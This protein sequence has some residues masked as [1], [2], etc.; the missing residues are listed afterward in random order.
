[1]KPPRTL[2][3]AVTPPPRVYLYV[4]F[5]SA[6]QSKGDSVRRQEEMGD[7]F[8]RERHIKINEILRIT[9]EGVSGFRGRNRTHGALSGFLDLM[10][11]KKIPQGSE[12]WVEN[13]DRLSRDYLTEA[14]PVFMAIV[15]AGITIVT[16]DDG[17]EFSKKIIN[18]DPGRMIVALVHMST[19]HD[20]SEIKSGRGKEAW[21]GKRKKIKTLKLTKQ[22]PA[23][24]KLSDDRTDFELIDDRV[25][26]VRR[27][28]RDRARGIGVFRL[29]REL[30]KRKVPTWGRGKRRAYQW[31][32]S[33]VSKILQ[34]RSVLGEFQA[35]LLED[36]KRVPEGEVVLEY[37]PRIISNELFEQVQ[38]LR[39]EDTKRTG[40]IGGGVPNLFTW[41]TKCARTGTPANYLNK[42]KWTYLKSE[43]PLEDGR[44]TCG[45]PY[46]DFE[47][48]FLTAI[49][50][51]D[52]TRIFGEDEDTET[53][54]RE[55]LLS[56]AKHQVR[57]TEMELGRLLNL[58]KKTDGDLPAT[59]LNE[60]STL[61]KR[62]REEIRDV[63]RASA[64]LEKTRQARE[65]A[66]QFSDN[67]QRLLKERD[68]PEIRLAL[69]TEIRRIVSRI[70]VF[71]EVK[72]TVE[73]RA[74]REKHEAA[75]RNLQKRVKIIGNSPS[76]KRPPPHMVVTFKSVK[77]AKRTITQDHSGNVLVY[78]TD[79]NR[80]E[81][82]RPVSQ[83]FPDTSRPLTASKSKRRAK[84]R[85]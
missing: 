81:A 35:H 17:L 78:D 65:D 50:K 40:Q 34:N 25:A 39:S 75:M 60:M 22:A 36:K 18:K 83:V 51:L 4:R 68:K 5:S 11:E 9:D 57:K 44:P 70:D 85:S 47:T 37:F 58:I 14:V 63:E 48:R 28:F 26:I 66:R 23:W 6:E 52:L 13:L 62:Q 61:E 29:A 24:L 45:W 43:T 38:R 41:L 16:L 2:S 31:H 80:P 76:C 79:T 10:R 77:Q 3:E 53:E 21:I 20:H 55:E 82:F 46:Q 32:K 54:R 73:E 64:E 49:G 69:R 1:V 74:R 30:N 12:L 15:N 42:G 72:E 84:A 33:Y 19:A 71:F 27:L 67:F 7:Q 8:A 59:I 56:D